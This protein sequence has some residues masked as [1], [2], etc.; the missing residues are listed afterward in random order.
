M[1]TFVL[2][3]QWFKQFDLSFV[4]EVKLQGRKNLQLRV[5]ML[6]ALDLVNFAPVTG[7]GGDARSDFL[8]IY[9]DLLGRAHGAARD[10]IQLVNTHTSAAPN[11]WAPEGSTL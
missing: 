9:N 8:G 6:N 1:R 5:D 10:A 11:L 4:K 2:T 7:L 3:P